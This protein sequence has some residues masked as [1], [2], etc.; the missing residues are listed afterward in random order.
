M[1]SLSEWTA[2]QFDAGLNWGD[3]EWIKKRWGGK[4]ILKGIQDVE[5]A[6]LAV[7]SGADALIVSNHGGRQLDGALSSINALPDIVAAVGDQI[8]VHMDGGIRSGQDVLKARALGAR[9]T[10]IGRAFLYGLGAMGEA[11]V[12][13][14]LEVIHK[15]LDLTM[16]F[17]GHTNIE[18]VGTGILLP[19]T[20]PLP[21]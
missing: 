12:T 14:A 18:T 9:G 15:E 4:L 10:Y 21:S 7:A 19:G 2:K 8:E 16:A 13:K 20:Y 11:G 5:D 6:K 1:G 17:C 3:V